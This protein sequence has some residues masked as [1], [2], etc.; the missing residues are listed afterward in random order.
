MKGLSTALATALGAPVQ[1]PAI[2][3]Q[4]GFSTVQR[5]SS[6]QTVTWNALTWSKEDIGLDGLLVEA[7][8]VSG[9][10]I[11]G[12]ADGAIGATVLAQGVQD[13]T[14]TIWGYDAAATATA[15]VVW[16][17]TAVGASAQVGLRDVRIALR[18]KS[19]YVQAPRTFIGP[20]AGMN[21][22]LPAGASLR[23]NGLDYTLERRG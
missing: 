19:E 10:L 22:L 3:V 20:A 13:R 17:G 18:H 12:N 11:V 16:L 2:L 23:I 15:D 14:I 9:T 8:R 4:V 1:Q 7:L 6:F 21:G 5:W